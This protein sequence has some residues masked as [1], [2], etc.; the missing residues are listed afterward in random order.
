MSIKDA[1][2]TL[3]TVPLNTE[4]QFGLLYDP[5]GDT[6]QAMKGYSFQT[7]GELADYPTPPKIVRVTRKFDSGDP[8]SSVELNEILIIKNVGH[9]TMMHRQC[10]KVHSLLTRKCYR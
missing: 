4:I 9:T 7:V 3:F 8:K 1:G 5:V 6:K 10:V 2:G